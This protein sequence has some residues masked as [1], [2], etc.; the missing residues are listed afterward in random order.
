MKNNNLQKAKIQKNDEF[1]F[2]H[3]IEDS[4]IKWT[5]DVYEK[6]KDLY[7]VSPQCVWHTEY[8]Q[9]SRFYYI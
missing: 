5:D 1:Y 6:E 3:L 2:G 9:E 8:R 7:S 4:T